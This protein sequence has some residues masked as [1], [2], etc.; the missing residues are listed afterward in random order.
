MLLISLNVCADE[1][2]DHMVV[3]LV[4]FFEELSVSFSIA[5]V[6]FYIPIHGAQG[7]N[8]PISLATLVLFWF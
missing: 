2:L 4:F 6:P 7:F 3:L 1:L 8:F 5:F